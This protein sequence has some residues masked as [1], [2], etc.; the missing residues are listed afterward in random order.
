MFVFCL[1]IPVLFCPRSLFFFQFNIKV[2]CKFCFR[3]GRFGGVSVAPDG[4]VFLADGCKQLIVKRDNASLDCFTGQPFPPT[5]ADIVMT[6]NTI[7]KMS[8]PM[9]SADTQKM[10]TF[11]SQVEQRFTGGLLGSGSQL[12]KPGRTA[13]NIAWTPRLSG[14]QPD[15]NMFGLSSGNR[16]GVAWTSNSGVQPG[17]GMFGHAQGLSRAPKPSGV[18]SRQGFLGNIGDFGQLFGNMP[19]QNLLE[20]S[21]VFPTGQTATGLQQTGRGW[22]PE[23][24]QRGQSGIGTGQVLGQ[25]LRQ[26]SVSLSSGSLLTSNAG[27]DIP[28]FSGQ[29]NQPAKMP[30]QSILQ[31]ILGT[32]KTNSHPQHRLVKNNRSFVGIIPF[33]D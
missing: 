31:E 11:N 30:T 14:A 2:S 16:H 3:I 28:T 10:K 19:T 33:D 27:L 5:P 25:V 21:V 1:C 8:G 22:L 13:T 20:P 32:R 26:P 7:L 6:G 17:Q 4:C 9:S 23:W 12:K 15:Q 29:L 18:N 24:G